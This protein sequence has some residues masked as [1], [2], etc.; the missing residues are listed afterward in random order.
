GVP[1][2]NVV[3]NPAGT[4]LTALTPPG[5][6]GNAPVVIT[7]AGGSATVPGGYTYTTPVPPVVSLLLP[8]SGTTAGG[9]PFTIIGSNLTGATSV[10][11]GGNAATS[12]LVDAGGTTLTGVTP[13]GIAG[14]VDVVVITPNGP[15]T[16]P[17]G[18]TYA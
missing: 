15:A 4:S 8:P 16:V 13:P 2:T 17:G 14:I 9:T 18:Y 11:F 10:T 1:A 5:A 3:V 12:I 6:A 7:T